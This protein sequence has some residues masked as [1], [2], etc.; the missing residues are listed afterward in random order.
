MAL[1]SFVSII[2]QHRLHT[3]MLQIATKQMDEYVFATNNNTRT[4]LHLRKYHVPFNL[5]I[6]LIDTNEGRNHAV[7]KLN[8]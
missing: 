4:A 6:S 3:L 8:P 2:Y 7:T 1:L 5:L